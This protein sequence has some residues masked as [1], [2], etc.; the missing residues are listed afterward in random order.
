MFIKKHIMSQSKYNAFMK[1]FSTFEMKW[2]QE[3]SILQIHHYKSNKNDKKFFQN[4]ISLP[5]VIM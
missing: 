2:L 5:F 4:R 3:F 1:I